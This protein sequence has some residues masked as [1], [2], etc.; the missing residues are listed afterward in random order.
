MK[1]QL[2]NF[3]TAK[4]AKEKGFD[5]EVRDSYHKVEGWLHDNDYPDT[6]NS[7]GAVSAPTQSLLQK[8]LR[9]THSI[10]VQPMCCYHYQLRKQYHLGIMFI[11]KENKVHTMIINETD[12]SLDTVNRYYSSYEEALEEGLYEALKLIKNED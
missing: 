11:N 1:E 7:L 5:E 6:W 12:K 4:L 9:D 3:E 8:W 2:V 10:E